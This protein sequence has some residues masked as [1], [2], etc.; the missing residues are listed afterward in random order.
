MISQVTFLPVPLTG[1]S[2]KSS[3]SLLRGQQATGGGGG[4]AVWVVGLLVPTEITSAR[5]IIIIK[6]R[7]HF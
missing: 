7:F 6:I 4:G 1:Y 2:I 5:T 3:D